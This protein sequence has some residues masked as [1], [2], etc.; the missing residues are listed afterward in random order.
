MIDNEKYK[1]VLDSGLLLDHY[2]LLCNIKN[3]VKLSDSK[4]IQGFINLLT[5]KGY[6]LDD[7]VT[8]K[9]EEL[10]KT[11]GFSEVVSTPITAKEVKEESFALWVQG[12]HKR[13]Q[14]KLVKL[15]GSRQIRAKIERK[16]YSFLPNSTDLGRALH[17]SIKTYK[18][19]DYDKV[20]S[21][22]MTYLE[23]CARTNHWFPILGNY[24]MKNGA[25]QMVTEM[26]VE[27]EAPATNQRVDP[28]DLF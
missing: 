25:S 16:P 9:G 20:E 24:I 4:R 5:K 15:T 3:G 17:K 1:E 10:I 19:K 11:S 27:E 2:F 26:D 7:K 12:L 8:D 28:K 6:I 23:T 22:L 18:L 14:E 21:T 13:L